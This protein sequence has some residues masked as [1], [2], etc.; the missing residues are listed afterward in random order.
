M[1]TPAARAARDDRAS[2]RLCGVTGRPFLIDAHLDLA[3]NAVGKH[4]DLRLPIDQL[5]RTEFG[6]LMAAKT[7][8]PTVCLPAL[9]DGGVGL[10]FATIFSPSRG[11]V[12]NVAG[13]SYDSPDEARAIGLRQ[14]RYYDELAAAGEVSL[15][16]TRSDLDR[17]LATD[18]TIARPALLISMEGA[19]PIREMAEVEQWRA[20]G[21]RIIGPAWAR[22]RFG[23]GT[24]A[25]GGLTDLGRE[26][27]AEMRRARLGLDLAHQSDDG[28]WESLDRFD[29]PVC[30][31]HANC[32]EIVPGDRQIT[33]EMIR[34]IV[35]RDGVI[36][37]VL[38]NRYLRPGYQHAD[39]KAV[40][41]A[42]VVAH[43]ERVCAIAGSTRHVGI[44][45]DLDGGLGLEWTPVG[46]E[47]VADLPKIGDA[48]RAAGWR[49]ADVDNVLHA[50]WSRWLRERLFA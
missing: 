50:N 13:P 28:F 43:I 41:M 19:D 26:L 40:R 12:F 45:S 11:S 47:S 21:L 1:P 30:V 2:G 8:T 5:R 9:R 4:A 33:D 25:P 6:R 22:T 42:E 16:R 38:Y 17:A 39:G 34:A 20:A 18:S 32:R 14:M 37:I 48:L 44:G 7:E 15:V 10:V 49:D 27:L 36:G 24:G 23:G 3:F 31:S 46:L 29:G 35:E